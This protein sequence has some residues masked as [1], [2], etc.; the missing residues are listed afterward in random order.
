MNTTEKFTISVE[1]GEYVIKGSFD[2]GYIG[3]YKDAQIQ[4]GDPKNKKINK[5]LTT[6]FYIGGILFLVKL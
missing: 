5:S 2:F 4:M 3:T 1:D 6:R